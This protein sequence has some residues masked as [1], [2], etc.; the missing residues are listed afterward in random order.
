MEVLYRDNGEVFEQAA[1]KGC[2]CCI[3]GGVQDHVGWDLAQP[4]LVLDLEVGGPACGT[5]VRT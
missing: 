1:Q 5:G 3:P 2:G 4:D